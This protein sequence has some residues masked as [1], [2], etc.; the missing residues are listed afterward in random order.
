MI[1]SVD[2][3]RTGQTKRPTA[4]CH[5]PLSRHTTHLLVPD[6]RVGRLGEAHALH[7]R[8][9]DVVLLLQGQRP[10]QAQAG[11]PVV[12]LRVRVALVG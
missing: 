9:H 10:G 6:H 4:Y 2:F 1:A 5:N 11:G 7:Q 12:L 8:I 3:V